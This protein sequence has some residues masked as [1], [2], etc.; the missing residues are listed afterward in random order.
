MAEVRGTNYRFM[1]FP[2]SRQKVGQSTTN[3]VQ[4]LLII[5][6][7]MGEVDF[8]YQKHSS[9]SRDTQEGDVNWVAQII[10]NQKTRRQ[11]Y[12]LGEVEKPT[13]FGEGRGGTAGGGMWKHWPVKKQNSIKQVG[14]TKSKRQVLYSA[15]SS[16]QDRTKRFTL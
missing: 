1:E 2:Q 14:D 16:P 13:S 6:S 7:L 9:I 8:K 15:V 3:T 11:Y 5:T 10:R 4:F 12:I